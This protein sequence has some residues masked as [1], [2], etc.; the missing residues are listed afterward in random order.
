MQRLRFTLLL[1]VLAL[2]LPAQAQRKITT[3][4][5]VM[6]AAPGDDYFLATY[7]QYEAYLK[8]I[9]AE[10]DRVK[11]VD[12]GPTEEGRR[13]W[14][15]IV[16]APEN[17][18]NIARLQDIS[19]KMAYAEGITEAQARQWSKEGK[20]VVWIDGGLHASEVLGFTQLI[21][22]IHQL[23]SQND[24]ETLRILRDVVVLLVHANPDGMEMVSSNY[25]RNPDPTKRRYTPER[26]YQKYVGHDNNRDFYMSTQKETQNMNRQ[27]YLEW[28][29]Q[30]LYN[31]HQSGPAGTTLFCPPFRDPASYLFDPM[32][33]IG[34]DQV[35]A[36]MH[37]RFAAEGKAGATTREGASFSVWYN[38][39]LRT[40]SY[41]HNI[42]GI[43]T[44]SAGSPTPMDIPFV[45]S[46]MLQ[47]KTTPFPIAPQEKWH[48]RQAVE[49]SIAANRG[50]LD[51]ASR[52]KDDLLFNIWRM[53]MNSIER[54]S[55]DHWTM[56]PKRI[57]ELTEKIARDRAGAE[58]GSV[59]SN[60]GRFGGTAPMKYY[61]DLLKPE[62]RD[63]RGYILPANQKDFNTAIKFAQLMHYMGI[64]AHRATADF[65]VNGKRYPKGSLIYKTNQAFRP[66]VLDMF[67][68][69]NYPNDLRYPG[70]PPIPPYDSAGWTLAM[71]MGL[72]YDRIL[73]DFNGPFERIN[74][75][76][77]FPAGKV[78]GSGAAGY[79]LSHSV[80]DS[81]KAIN[82]LL[83]AGEDV[84][85]L[86]AKNGDI[87]IPA[88]SSTRQN[89]AKIAAEDH[90]TF[91]ALD[92]KPK[93][94]VLKLKRIRIGLWDTVGGSM[95]SGWTRWMFEQY[96][97]PFEVVYPPTLDQGDLRSKFDVLVFV[98]GA[99]GSGRGG[100]AP[101]GGASSANLLPEW[102][103]RQGRVT[104]ETTLPQ[105]KKFLESGGTVLT[106]GSSTAMA[107]M[108]GLPIG[109]H[110]VE[111]TANG[112]ERR[113]PND[114]FY[115]PGSLLEVSIDNT[116]PL[117]YG[118][119]TRADLFFDN[120]P[121]F[122]L[123][124]EASLQGV[125]PVAWFKDAKPLRSGWAWG[126]HYLDGGVAVA[127]A[128]VG[129]GKLFLYGPEVIFR[130]QPHGT[131]KLFFNALYYGT[132][133]PTTLN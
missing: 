5:E 104:R 2:C 96:N 130:A 90:L 66:H 83:A 47:N 33:M 3:P 18:K 34:V 98:T 14:M 81:F 64:V 24:E 82:K 100:M 85:W 76:A 121:V 132:A 101:Q 92:T 29:P 27:L 107:G 74:G 80:N 58:G 133:E 84:Y 127:E 86:K 94:E 115:V 38:G 48:F 75:F 50:I 68:P 11:L 125:K 116:N 51:Y 69:Q 72:A 105:I 8:K 20:A 102:Q 46:R 23:V 123:K 41:F 53:G 73:D 35:G 60:D 15:T 9:A 55:R 62:W 111:K 65:E 117:A 79:V 17:I 119:D 21:E 10:S 128:K 57:E 77:E 109:D 26:L 118:M 93:G 59:A 13:Q 70:G 28:L 126:Q 56:I 42:I 63:P 31:H 32:M 114:K 25:M 124:P 54:G 6:G 78:E 61:K 110:L 113:L 99:V 52:H 112:S 40:T 36:A 44:E 67:E 89:V 19:R 37:A 49:Y 87:Y 71:Q 16:S 43:L 1:T 97:F 108:L 22:M 7:T 45:P 88:K 39:G 103:Q 129:E 4:K 95:S 106:I 91:T 12:I 120:S 122:K 30:I 131:F